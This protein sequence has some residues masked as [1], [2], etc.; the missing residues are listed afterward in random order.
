MAS[1]LERRNHLYSK[2]NESGGLFSKRNRQN[3]EK[4]YNFVDYFTDTEPITW[5]IQFELFAQLINPNYAWKLRQQLETNYTINKIFSLS[6]ETSQTVK[7]SGGQKMEVLLRNT[8]KIDEVYGDASW[9]KAKAP[10][11]TYEE[12]EQ[13]TPKPTNQ[14]VPTPDGIELGEEEDQRKSWVMP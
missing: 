2:L 1:Y 6:D 3:V 8:C 4:Y 5:P 7:G 12:E 14:K 13:K 9:K 11:I 10:A